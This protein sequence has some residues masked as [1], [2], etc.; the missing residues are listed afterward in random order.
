MTLNE[1]RRR[2]VTRYRSRDR[3]SYS[4][5]R[6]E[7]R[8]YRDRRDQSRGRSRE[9]RHRDDSQER[10]R[11]S[12]HRDRRESRGRLGEENRPR[13]AESP[14]RRVVSQER[15]RPPGPEENQGEFGR[16]VEAVGRMTFLYTGH[17]SFGHLAAHYLLDEI[18]RLGG[19]GQYVFDLVNLGR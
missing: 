19:E 3:R 4:P 10:R 2:H 1:R 18:L 9:R 15:C 5:R 16:P 11:R 8:G 17:G 12:G 13:R 6:P 14:P 7:R